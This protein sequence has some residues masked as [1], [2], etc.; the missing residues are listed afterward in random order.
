MNLSH[1][2][3]NTKFPLDMIIYFKK[4]EYEVPAG[5]TFTLK[6]PHKLPE[7][8]LIFGVWSEDE[9]F[10]VPREFDTITLNEPYVKS[11]A[12]VDSVIIYGDFTLKTTKTKVYLRIYGYAPPDTHADFL[13]TQQ[14]SN[15][16][17][18]DSRYS[19]SQLLFSGK[20]TL[21]NEKTEK[22]YN[23]GAHYVSAVDTASDIVLDYAFDFTPQIMTWVS[24]LVSGVRTVSRTS[25]GDLTLGDGGIA[26]VS[27]ATMITKKEARIC[28]GINTQVEPAYFYVRAY[29]DA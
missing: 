9:N 8:P 10:D 20:I 29:A 18:L 2:R 17:L 14:S 3:V 25:A 26:W 28:A 22:I 6:I 13:P 11:S 1:F 19:Y 15:K 27:G 21:P 16:L 4:T 7:T 24:A 12:T 5:Q 23:V